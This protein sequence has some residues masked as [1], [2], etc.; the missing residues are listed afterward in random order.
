MEGCLRNP[1]VR[2]RDADLSWVGRGSARSRLRVSKAAGFGEATRSRALEFAAGGFDCPDLQW[3]R[4]ELVPQTHDA[5]DVYFFTKQCLET[6]AEV[7]P[8][9]LDA[10]DPSLASFGGAEE[11][12]DV[13]GQRCEDVIDPAFEAFRSNIAEVRARIA[14][15]RPVSALASRCEQR[16]IAQRAAARAVLENLKSHRAACSR[17][18]SLLVQKSNRV[19]VKLSDCLEKAESAMKALESVEL[20]ES[21]QSETR[22]CLADV[23]PRDRI[24]RFTGALEGEGAQLLQ[25]LEK[26]QRQDSQLEGMCEQVA[27]R[28]EQLIEEDSARTSEGMIGRNTR[29]SVEKPFSCAQVAEVSTEAKAIHEEQARAQSE[30]PRLR[31]LVPSAGAAPATVLEDEKR[32]ALLRDRVTTACANVH[33]ALDQLQSCWDRQHQMFVQRL[34]E[35]AYVQSKVRYVER[36]AALLEEEVNAQ[37]NHAQ[38]IVRLQKLPKAYNSALRE[39]ALRRQF[40]ER[41]VAQAEKARAALSRMVEAENSRRGHER[42]SCYLPAD[43][44]QGLGAFAPV[45]TVEVPDFDAELPEI[46]M[47]SLEAVWDAGRLDTAS[48]SSLRDNVLSSMGEVPLTQGSEAPQGA[49]EAKEDAFAAAESRIAELEARNKA[50]EEQ[51]AMRQEQAATSAPES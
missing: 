26:L 6:Q 37:S 20:H 8:E 16:V 43:L 35:V 38:H 5:L 47:S 18:I 36:Q 32:S 9:R 19:Q 21:L 27:E 51:L 13:L 3:Q 46:L 30:L 2:S 50:L 23:V 44:V 17:S 15:S 33:T 40:R 45:A 42:Y 11:Q 49:S 22:R 14:E 24:L 41:Y 10:K 4:A 31:A 28:V 48:M 29:I 25:R 1:Q 39:V 12:D 7:I 34:R